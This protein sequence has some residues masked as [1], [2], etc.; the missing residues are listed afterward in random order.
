MTN[1]EHEKVGLLLVKGFEQFY[2]P[3]RIYSNLYAYMF[4]NKH[5]ILP[6]D[7]YYPQFHE[8]Q[9][10]KQ[11]LFSMHILLEVYILKLDSE[12]LHLFSSLNNDIDFIFLL[13]QI[14]GRPFPFSCK[15][16]M[17]K[18]TRNVLFIYKYLGNRTYRK[19]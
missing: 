13:C 18:F 8:K 19:H 14:Y 1:V 10:F 16:F 3:E 15:H 7:R 2:F 5:R 4:E 9:Y 17:E 11:F 6:I 12:K